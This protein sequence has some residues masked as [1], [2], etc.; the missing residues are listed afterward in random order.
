[1]SIITIR[2]LTFDEA[3]VAKLASIMAKADALLAAGAPVSHEGDTLHIALDDGSRANITG[4]ATTAIAASANTIEWPASYQQGWITIENIRIPLTAPAD[5][6]ALAAQAG[7]YYAQIVQRAR[8]LKDAAIAAED[9]S[10]LSAI[11]IDAG[12]PQQN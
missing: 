11:D 5:G 7:D 10:A 12:W 8:D 4:M 3:R 6:I 9:D 2:A 1:M